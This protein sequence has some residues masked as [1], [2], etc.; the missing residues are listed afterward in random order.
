MTAIDEARV[1]EIAAGC[2]KRASE[3]SD[4]AELCEIEA[5]A[6]ELQKEARW[7]E[8]ES[9]K[10]YAAMRRWRGFYNRL[11]ELKRNAKAT[12]EDVEHYRDC[13]SVLRAHLER[14]A[15]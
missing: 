12:R 6:L 15:S 7:A 2:L 3:L 11:S 10:S 14:S 8:W 1:A 13:A 4:E 5:A 9:N